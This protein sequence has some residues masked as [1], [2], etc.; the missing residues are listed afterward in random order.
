MKRG[1]IVPLVTAAILGVLVSVAAGQVLLASPA[2]VELENTAA[3]KILTTGRGFT[4]YVFTRDAPNHDRC[5]GISG[6]RA[7]WPLLKAS[8]R[9]IAGPGVKVALLGSIRLASGT[10]QVTYAGHPLY[11]YA[12]DFA[13]RSTSY[14][15]ARQFGGFWYALHASG[16]I[17]K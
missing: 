8:G 13:P 17:V 4:L 9:T 6:C 5:V 14:V 15:G 2:K 7:V 11:T 16:K 3:G 1:L 12:G 10:R